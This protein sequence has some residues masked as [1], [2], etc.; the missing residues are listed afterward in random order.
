MFWQSAITLHTSLKHLKD[1]HY[2]NQI[3][4]RNQRK[5]NTKTQMSEEMGDIRNATS[6][7]VESHWLPIN[8]LL[9]YEVNGTCVEKRVVDKRLREI[10]V[11]RRETI[12][13]REK[14]NCSRCHLYKKATTREDAGKTEDWIPRDSHWIHLREGVWSSA[15]RCG[16]LVP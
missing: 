16:I 6:T 15:K 8:K 11:D 4:I 3:L 12:F 5:L 14:K 1:A 9:R 10:C 13:L 7:E 2:K